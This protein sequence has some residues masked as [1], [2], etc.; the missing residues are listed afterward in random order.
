M[1][2]PNCGQQLADRRISAGA[3]SS[4]VLGILSLFCLG[5]LMGIPAIV[6]G[7]ISRGKI[8]R[9]GGTLTGSGMALAGLIMGYLTTILVVLG[10]LSLVV[11]EDAIRAKLSGSVCGGPESGPGPSVV[12]PQ[13]GNR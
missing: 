2:C 4:L 3:V 5:P 1:F 12:Q 7:H 9:S 8:L 11:F 13:N 10:F 6:C